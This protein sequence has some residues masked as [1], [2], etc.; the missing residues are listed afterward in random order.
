[1]IE[2]GLL[3][4]DCRRA[5]RA[6]VT[7]TDTRWS[8]NSSMCRFGRIRELWRKPKAVMH[9]RLE[10]ARH[11]D[12]PPLAQAD[13]VDGAKQEPSAAAVALVAG[14]RELA[15]GFDRDDPPW[16]GER[17]LDHEAH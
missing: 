11:L 15:V 13:H 2:C 5:S 1:G 6:P 14:E 10:E 12:D 9:L 7:S 8:Q 17:A 16:R 3:L 4:D